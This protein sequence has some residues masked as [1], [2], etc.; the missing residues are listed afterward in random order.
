MS[1][2]WTPDGERPVNREPDD[3]AS[4]SAAA[5][6]AS[7]AVPGADQL[8]PEEAQA[9]AAEMAKVRQ[10]LL[11]V[12]PEL[13]VN[14]HLM[15]LYELAA[16]HLSNQPPNIEQARLPIDAMKAVLDSCQGRLGEDE[17]ALRD[18][19]T[20]LQH[21]FVTLRTEAEAGSGARDDG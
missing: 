3:S 19:L 6:G 9:M 7:G 21:A 8:S 16:I 1:T 2:I 18:A 10:Q 14:N 4:T 12:P 11:E 17:T 13:V 5:P 20:Q 15:G